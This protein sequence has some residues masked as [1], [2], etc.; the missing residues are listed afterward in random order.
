MAP[1]PIP[2]PCRPTNAGS[3]AHDAGNQVSFTP[4][5]Q[6]AIPIGLGMVVQHTVQSFLGVPPFDAEHR[7]RRRVQGRRHLGNALLAR[8]SLEQDAH[9]IGGPERSAGR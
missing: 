9:P 3:S 1:S 6:L 7:A 8:I 4:I 2:P 5:V